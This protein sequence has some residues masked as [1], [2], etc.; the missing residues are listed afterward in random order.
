MRLRDTGAWLRPYQSRLLLQGHDHSFV[1]IDSVSM[2]RPDEGQKKRQTFERHVSPCNRIH[3]FAS[4]SPFASLRPLLGKQVQTLG[5]QPRAGSNPSYESDMSARVKATSS[6]MAVSSAMSHQVPCPVFCH[7]V[8]HLSESAS[9]PSQAIK[10]NCIHS[11]MQSSKFKAES[12][13][14]IRSLASISYLKR[15]LLCD[16]SINFFYSLR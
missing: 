3:N 8:V 4:C 1:L 15:L 11:H 9:I 12:T 6:G 13:K 16:R 5:S 10:V 14:K 7:H 2:I